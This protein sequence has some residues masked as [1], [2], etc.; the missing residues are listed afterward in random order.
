[1]Y[2]SQS[3]HAIK[4]TETIGSRCMIYFKKIYIQKGDSLL[5]WSV[6]SPIQPIIFRKSAWLM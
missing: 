2:N 1:M 5:L 3:Y 6:S 4:S